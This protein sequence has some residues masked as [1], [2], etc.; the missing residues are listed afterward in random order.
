MG[1]VEGPSG[2]A[3]FILGFGFGDLNTNPASLLTRFSRGEER[4]DFR[5]FQD[6]HTSVL[7]Y[8]AILLDGTI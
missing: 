5:G 3:G 6:F 7:Q 2:K 4:I 1:S 8:V